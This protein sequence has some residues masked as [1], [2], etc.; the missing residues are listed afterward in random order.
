MRAEREQHR[1]CE[2]AQ[3]FRR[4]RKATKGRG[5]LRTRLAPADG[6]GAGA[7]G[8][9]TAAG[10]ARSRIGTA[11]AAATGAVDMEA[12]GEDLDAAAFGPD[13]CFWTQ[14]RTVASYALRFL[15]NN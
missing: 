13:A 12:A 3:W 11:A 5:L 6:E 1:L 14:S 9:G 4:I 10:A 2:P 8:A 15:T 7:E